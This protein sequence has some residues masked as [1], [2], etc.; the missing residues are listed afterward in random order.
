MRVLVTGASGSG[1]TTLARALAEHL[2][3]TH[4]DL[5][6]YYWL[7][8]SPPFRAKR[9][10]RERLRGCLGDLQAARDAVVS[11][12]LV[13]WGEDLEN[14]FDL[15]VFLYLS[16]AIR[17]ARLRARETERFGTVDPAFLEWAAQYDEGPAEGRSLAKHLAWIS[18]R[19]CAVL[20]ID[21]DLSTGERL[22]IVLDAIERAARA[23]GA[24][25][26]MGRLPGRF[27]F[28]APVLQVADLA[29]S[30]AYYRRQLGFALEFS[31]EGFDASVV[32]DGCRVHLNCAAPS[33]RDPQAFEAA[34]HLDVCFGV[35]DA[36]SLASELAQ[37]GADI[38]VQL[39]E[40]PYG[41]EFYVR[42]PDGYILGFVQPK[43]PGEG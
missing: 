8:T 25:A 12:S 21:G 33:P 26:S 13:G 22:R 42:D 34:E 41:W 30:L 43:P 28:V 19:K 11:G 29:R 38:S 16:S 15:V 35:G 31:Y 3:W 10:A 1:T 4:L 6:D 24:G 18:T 23:L 17:V 40:M 2:R 37:A 7:P 9:D 32:R 36:A 5:D 20:R 27:D 14:G 39:R